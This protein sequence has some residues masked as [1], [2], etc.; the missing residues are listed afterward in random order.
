MREEIHGKDKKGV[1]SY[2][3]TECSLCKHSYLFPQVSSRSEHPE[4]GFTVV[5][6]FVSFTPSGILGEMV[7]IH[8]YFDRI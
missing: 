8:S 1:M 4:W 7:N 2:R 3:T 6:Y 5:L